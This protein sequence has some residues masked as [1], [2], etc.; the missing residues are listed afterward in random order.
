VTAGGHDARRRLAT[1][2]GWAAGIGFVLVMAAGADRPPPP[3]FLLVVGFGALVGALIG[4][5]LPD[6]LGLWDDRGAAPAIVR[7]ALWGFS[8]GLA[9]MALTTV[10]SSGEPSVDVDAAARLI[11]FT[12]VGAAGALGAVA[13]TAIARILD[14]RHGR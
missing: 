12:A 8:G 14:R 2:L 3:G 1:R 5:L 6:L 11:G 10:V 13:A 9:L 7:A 4:R